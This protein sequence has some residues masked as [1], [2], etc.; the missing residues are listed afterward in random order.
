[1]IGPLTTVVSRQFRL[2]AVNRPNWA[3]GHAVDAADAVDRAMQERRN[4]LLADN[5]AAAI[6]PMLTQWWSTAFIP[7]AH[8][9]PTSISGAWMQPLL[10]KTSRPPGILR[11]MAAA[12]RAEFVIRTDSSAHNF[13]PVR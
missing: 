7:V 1:M 2:G 5:S 6:A 10:L 13:S 4:P 8:S 12:S 11:K 9:P 3:V